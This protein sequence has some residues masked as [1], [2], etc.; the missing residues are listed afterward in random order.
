LLELQ[1]EGKKRIGAADFA[2]GYRPAQD[3]E[4]GS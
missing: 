1:P 2:R 4:L 3:E